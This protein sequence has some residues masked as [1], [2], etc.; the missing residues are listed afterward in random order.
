MRG[1]KSEFGFVLS[2]DR[3]RDPGVKVSL[4]ENMT[5]KTERR[6]SRWMRCMKAELGLFGVVKSCYLDCA[7]V[8]QSVA[9]QG[10][11]G[12][13]LLRGRHGGAKT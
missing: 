6:I 8:L 1:F 12:R 13:R 2:F 10:R 7:I 11:L 5:A 3:K 9:A 4:H